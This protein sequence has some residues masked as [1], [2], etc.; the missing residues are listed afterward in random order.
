MLFTLSTM[1]KGRKTREGAQGS[2]HSLNAIVA[3][4]KSCPFAVSTR[5]ISKIGENIEWLAL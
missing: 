1:M 5:L 4:S 3:Q 2:H